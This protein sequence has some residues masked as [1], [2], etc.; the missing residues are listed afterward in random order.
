MANVELLLYQIFEREKWLLSQLEQQQKL[1]TQ[2]MVSSLYLKG[3]KP[4]SWLL[5]GESWTANKDPK[6]LNSEDLI[7]GLLFPPP[8]PNVFFPSMNHYAYQSRP[9]SMADHGQFTETCDSNRGGSNIKQ[10]QVDARTQLPESENLQELSRS[11]PKNPR[12]SPFQIMK[13]PTFD[14]CVIPETPLERITRSRS[15][16]RALEI[17]NSVKAKSKN[18][19]SVASIGTTGYTSRMTRYRSALQKIEGQDKRASLAATETQL[20]IQLP[21]PKEG[22]ITRSR[23]RQRALEIRNSVKAKSKNQTSVSSTGTMGY[24]GRM[25]RYR[26]ALQKI[27]CEDKIAS[28]AATE[29][30]LAIQPPE[31][32]KGVS[33][34]HVSNSLKSKQ[35]TH[36]DC[37]INADHGTKFEVMKQMGCGAS[38]SRP[39]LKNEPELQAQGEEVSRRSLSNSSEPIVCGLDYLV[40][41]KQLVFDD[42]AE[43]SLS[44]AGTL[45]EG[46]DEEIKL[47]ASVTFSVKS[48]SSAG[49]ET[50]S[51]S[52]ANDE[53]KSKVPK[54]VEWRNFC[55]SGHEL[56]KNSNFQA[57]GSEGSWRNISNPNERTRNNADFSAESKQL[58]CA[59]L[60]ECSLN[61]NCSFS[62]GSAPEILQLG[63]PNRKVPEEMQTIGLQRAESWGV[64]QKEQSEALSKTVE[65]Q[66][67]L[68]ID[69]A[70]TPADQKVFES[71]KKAPGNVQTC[72]TAPSDLKFEVL[73]TSENISNSRKKRCSAASASSPRAKL[74]VPE[75]AG[76]RTLRSRF[77]L[78]EKSVLQDKGDEIY[79]WNLFTSN[80]ATAHRP[81]SLAEHEQQIYGGLEASC[82]NQ[83]GSFSEGWEQEF[84]NVG[85]LKRKFLEEDQMIG[86]QRTET[87]GSSK[88]VLSELLPKSVG[89]KGVLSLN[90]SATSEEG[91][92]SETLKRTS[93]SAQI[94]VDN[95]ASW[96]QHKRRKREKERMKGFITSP[97]LRRSRGRVF[98][99]LQ[100]ACLNFSAKAESDL[101]ERSSPQ[102][103]N[104]SLDADEA[105]P[106]LE[107]FS[108]VEPLENGEFE[109]PNSKRARISSIE[110]RNSTSFLTPLPKSHTPEVC[111]SLPNGLLEHMY[112]RNGYAH[113]YNCDEQVCETDEVMLDSKPCAVRSTSLGRSDPYRISSSSSRFGWN[114][115]SP[116]SSTPSVGR[117]SSKDLSMSISKSAERI[118]GMKPSTCF[119]I[120]EETSTGEQDVQVVEDSERTH[121][122]I[123]SRERK[124]SSDRKPL[125]DITSISCNSSIL[126]PAAKC[127]GR[128]CV[129]F[130]DRGSNFIGQQMEENQELRKGKD[131]HKKISIADKENAN[132][133]QHR[134]STRNSSSILQNES[135]KSKLATRSSEGIGSEIL[136]E[137]HSKRNNIVSSIS[138]FIPLVQQKQT[139]PAI[140]TG[141]RDIKVKALEAAEA[142][143]RLEEQKENERKLRKEAA[144]LERT[145]IE[146]ENLKT[147]EEKLKKL[148]EDRKRREAEA[149]AKKRQREEDER[150][151]RERKRKCIEDAQRQRREFEERLRVE[152]EDKE[153]KRK[154]MEEKEHKRKELAAGAKKR[155]RMEKEREMTARK[156]RELE[157]K[158]RKTSKV[159]S[160]HTSS[161]SGNL[162]FFLEP[163]GIGE[164]ATTLNGL[165]TTSKDDTSNKEELNVSASYEITPYKDSDCEEDDEEEEDNYPRKHIPSWARKENVNLMVIKQQ[166]TDPDKIFLRAKCGDLSEVYGSRRISTWSEFSDHD[167]DGD[168]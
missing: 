97:R 4:P 127:F 115:K 9:F 69:V 151:E 141:K 15:R 152:K 153:Q 143:K 122:R 106:E 159:D 149:A 156:K 28:L 58:A 44:Q 6:E 168:Y 30:Q 21:E 29:T 35:K 43:C 76:F 79:G 155:Q 31:L 113:L 68:S 70:A 11:G 114:V 1:F 22:R 55:E 20:A 12:N 51:S 157:T 146:Q 121:K 101:E 52:N 133:L 32:K 2:A 95:E 163:P 119:R 102:C 26:S 88:K 132:S 14:S 87:M 139:A 86:L 160:R 59:D 109:M 90:V 77:E 84:V 91:K 108:F 137:K 99:Q 66:G 150:R 164:I 126:T 148:E 81:D 57:N 24:T 71:K 27:E 131:S 50:H 92:L 16:Q 130:V 165:G 93:C 110:L 10:S 136:Q 39:E 128:F 116:A 158:G 135:G 17:R 65:V 118:V 94:L 124:D 80:E 8:K 5:N 48:T 147:K 125:Q 112:L 3:I 167:E 46:R 85:S 162:N 23:S 64:P 25:T 161:V 82:L 74:V 54:P 73:V 38:L 34:S 89:L 120:E 144:R 123:K 37:S 142:A 145:K 154:A 42:L 49:K 107:G 56:K 105:I 62:K 72:A 19:T 129:D 41:P 60:H 40:E 117:I 103:E 67:A 100:S 63:T 61:Q 53:E 138:S 33:L 36:H 18:R 134:Y 13:D 111:Q 78:K 140:L 98:S 7:P 166:N 104:G 45:L 96:P 47:E 75:P 83:A